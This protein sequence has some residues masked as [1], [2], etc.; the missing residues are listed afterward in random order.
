MEILI[1]NLQS[2]ELKADLND[3]KAHSLRFLHTNRFRIR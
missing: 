2:A 1:T 3:I